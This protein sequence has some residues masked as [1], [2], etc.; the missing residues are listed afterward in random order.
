MI[1][2]EIFRIRIFL[3]HAHSQVSV[4]PFLRSYLRL[5]EIWTEVLD[6]LDEQGDS[7]V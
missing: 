3:L 2:L 7:L 5:G 4:H 6:C 1:S